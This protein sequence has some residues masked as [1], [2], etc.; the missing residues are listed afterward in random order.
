MLRDIPFQSRLILNS[1]TSGGP[2]LR[3]GPT[4]INPLSE[5]GIAESDN[6]PHTPGVTA[7]PSSSSFAQKCAHVNAVSHQ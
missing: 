4:A 3:T 2:N 6:E 7:A 5:V 1:S